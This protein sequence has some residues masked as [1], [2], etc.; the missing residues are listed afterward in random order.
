[1]A[2]S[3]FRG[4]KKDAGRGYRPPVP[5]I[6]DEALCIRHWD[7]SETS[8]TVSLFGRGH[9]LIRGL[10][11]GARRERGRFGGGFDL[12]TRGEILALGKSDRSL[13]TLTDWTMLETFPRLRR[14]LEASRAAFYLGDLL[15]RTMP[16]QDPHPVSYDAAVGALRAIDSGTRPLE[17]IALFQ[18]RLLVDIGYAPDL[19]LPAGSGPV[20]FDPGEGRF[21][22]IPVEGEPS[23]ERSWR[24]RRDT[25]DWIGR[26]GE[27][28]V[29]ED[30]RP[31]HIEDRSEGSDGETVPLEIVARAARLLAVCLRELIG[32]EPMSMRQFLPRLPRT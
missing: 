25:V 6:E 24:V 15:Q 31:S 28:E 8:Q 11:K 4:S 9:G 1:M 20:L 27:R 23:P 10:A 22:S 17:A 5:R 18:W 12:F 7:W 21:I 32:E 13:L 2:S 30:D 29:P 14:D 3:P 16:S 26:L 19:S